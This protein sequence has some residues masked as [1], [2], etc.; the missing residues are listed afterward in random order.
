MYIKLQERTFLNG[1][2]FDIRAE[3]GLVCKC[4]KGCKS[5]QKAQ[6]H[7]AARSAQ[8]SVDYLVGALARADHQMLRKDAEADCNLVY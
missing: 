1:L 3:L 4:C 8:A 6:N 7:R 5:E 2:P